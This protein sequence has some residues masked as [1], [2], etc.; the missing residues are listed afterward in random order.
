MSPSQ[1]GLGLGKGLAA[2]LLFRKIS[3]FWCGNNAFWYI[4]NTRMVQDFSFPPSRI[5]D[6]VCQKHTDKNFH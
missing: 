4:Y 5:I 3:V 1:S 6:D 2:V